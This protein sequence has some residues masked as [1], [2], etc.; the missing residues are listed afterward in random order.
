MEVIFLK[1]RFL[2]LLLVMMMIVSMFTTLGVNAATEAPTITQTTITVAQN[3]SFVVSGVANTTLDVTVRFFSPSNEVLSFDQVTPA[4]NGSYTATVQLKSGLTSGTGYAVKVSNGFA[5]A[6]LAVTVADSLKAIT[7]GLITTFITDVN[8]LTLDSLATAVTAV[9]GQKTTID[10]NISTLGAG[11][12]PSNKANYDTAVAKLATLKTDRTTYAGA[13]TA[14]DAAQAKIK[15]TYASKTEAQSVLADLNAMVSTFG[16]YNAAVKAGLTTAGFDAKMTAITNEITRINTV[17]IPDFVRQE[18]EAAIDAA[19]NAFTVSSPVGA[20][21]NSLGLPTAAGI[22]FAWDA[23]TDTVGAT[24]LAIAADGTVTHPT[25]TGADVNATLTLKGTK[26]SVTRTKTYA[27]AFVRVSYARADVIAAINALSDVTVANMKDRKADVR[28]TRAKVDA[29]NATYNFTP[30]ELTNLTAAE[31]KLVTYRAGLKPLALNITSTGT[32]NKVYTYTVTKNAE[33]VA[34]KA[35]SATGLAAF[36][37][38]TST[39]YMISQVYAT[40]NTDAPTPAATFAKIHVGITDAGI[41][42]EFT[43]GAS[44][45]VK[46]M[47][48]STLVGASPV[49]YSSAQEI[50]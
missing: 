49:I 47:T 1:N 50:Q 26:D 28:A 41:T 13:K 14:I 32:A 21:T 30:A 45:G 31:A 42:G 24:G 5:E 11:N 33:Y 2:P 9:D 15:T 17:V 29:T 46:V 36:D 27:L 10:N 8:A 34:E 4:G 22:T 25:G 20:T 44:N 3:G 6:S 7:E 23:Y 48:Q 39:F 16:G 43:L 37:Y 38:N 19:L 40:T 18:T 35:I 12:P